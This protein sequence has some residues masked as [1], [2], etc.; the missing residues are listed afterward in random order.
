MRLATSRY[1]NPTVATCGLRA[2]GFTNGVPRFKLDYPLV[3]NL[4]PLAPPLWALKLERQPFTRHYCA[5]LDD[6]GIDRIRRLLEVTLEISNVRRTH[7]ADGIVLLCYE[8]ERGSDPTKWCHRRIFA[9]WWTALTG[10]AVP[11]LDDPTEP[12]QPVVD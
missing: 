1:Q 3:M 12:R 9:D 10:E 11:E 2:C 8:D 5:H 6:L 7:T 4:T